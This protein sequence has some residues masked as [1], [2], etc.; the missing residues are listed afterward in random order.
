MFLNYLCLSLLYN[1]NICNFATITMFNKDCNKKFNKDFKLKFNL[2]E[3]AG[4]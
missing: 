1:G 4:E 2:N 3:L